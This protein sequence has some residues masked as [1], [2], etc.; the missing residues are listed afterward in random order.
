MWNSIGDMTFQ[1]M[2]NFGRYT[3]EGKLLREE[4]IGEKG[5]GL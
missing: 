2:Y 4:K 1:R 5:Y 3:F